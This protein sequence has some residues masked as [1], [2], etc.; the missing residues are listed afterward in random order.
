VGENPAKRIA[1]PFEAQ[2]LAQLAETGASLCI[3]RGAGG[4]E[5]ERVDRAILLSGVPARNVRV[6]DGSFAGFASIIAS[7]RLYVGYDSAGQ[8]V[9]AACGVPLLSIFAGFASQRMF[10]RWRPTGRGRIE[11]VKVDVPDPAIVLPQV[12]QALHALR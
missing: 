3:D 8:H 10:E 4:E 9:A 7:S 1:D 5:A 6:Y 2:L 11:I 12:V